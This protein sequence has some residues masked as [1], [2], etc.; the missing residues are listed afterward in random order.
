[1]STPWIGASLERREAER[2]IQGRGKFVDD[3][4]L[5]GML[6]AVVVR[7]P[8]AHARLNG[9]D[10]SAALE[11]PG[12]V[13]VFTWADL[14]D[15][16]KVIPQRT[17]P[18]PGMERFLQMPMAKSVVRYVGEPV[19]L[20]VAEDRY[21]A[22]DA[23]ELVFGDY[24]MLEPIVDA[25][26]AAEGAPFLHEERGTNLASAY[27]AGRGDIEAAFRAAAYTRKET[28]Y[29]HRHSAVPLE[30]RGLVA[31]WDAQEP[32]LRVFGAGK[33]PFANRAI[34]A[35]ML[36]LPPTQVELIE[37]DIGGSFGVR[38]DFYPE[39]FLIPFAAW[40]L[41]RPV[42]WIEDRR[43]HLQATNHSREMHCELEIAVDAAG[44]IQGMR[45][46]VLA[47]LG[48]Y[49][50]TNPGVMA[51]KGTQF[52]QGPYAIAHLDFEVQAAVTSK[53]PAGTY[54]GPGRYE[55]AFFRER[56]IDLAAADLGLDR[57]EF[58]RR[59]LITAEQM[60]YDAGALVP[61]QPTTIYDSGNYAAVLEQA[62]RRF[63]YEAMRRLDGREIDG[64]KHGIGLACFVESTGGGPG[65]HAR[66][67]LRRDG[68]FD[69]FVGSSCAGQGHETV[70]AQ[71]LADELG[72]S[73]DRIRVH[74]GST[75]FLEQ[76]FGAYHS[77]S[78]VM[79]GSAVM[80]AARAMRERLVAHAASRGVDHDAGQLLW[81]NGAVVSRTDSSLVATAAQL[82]EDL[83]ETGPY[84]RGA[85]GVEASFENDRLTYTFGVQLAHVS[86]DPATA[87]VRVE[88]FLC[89]ED[90]G[91]MLNPA[92][93]HGQTIGAAVQGLGGTFLDE[94]I[95][96]ESGQLVTGSFADYLL[97][98]ST[99]F[100]NVEAL[101]LEIARSP[102]NPLGA[103]GAGEGGIIGT[104]AAIAN[105][106]SSA[107]AS[108]GVSVTAL[109]LSL[110]KLAQMVRTARARRM[111]AA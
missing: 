74:H 101:G 18:L 70:M 72:I 102:S 108:N 27:R 90:L 78:A 87:Q 54:R 1:V 38:G 104:G 59:N 32:R 100:P 106:V 97:P 48:A 53:T 14:A 12:V 25:R 39:D 4:R 2:F 99:D 10:A 6:H 41:G 86:V 33:V 91:R 79:G 43:E 68:S 88:K 13:G 63:D 5:P 50:R 52:L 110:D 96:D 9:I 65:E 8:M 77:R 62:L 51:G 111:E 29:V 89:V 98:T 49:V 16:A 92:L 57:L 105:A 95:Y 30:T 107:L 103:K 76:G 83:P 20:V 73:F 15:Y 17:C 46:K 84:D 26:R 37:V 81:A 19:A 22:E 42:K 80:A 55:S 56:L 75:C 23:A 93:V 11:L 24:D 109:P 66:I 61:G 60:P 64:R 34:L 94:F 47:D 21:I 58:R 67:E 7:S 31:Q 3:I 82:A 45:G 28:F 35:D 36:R 69:L 85:L 44:K 40:R 71:V